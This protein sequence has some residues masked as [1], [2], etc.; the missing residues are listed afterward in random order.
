M[1][2]RQRIERPK[3]HAG[4]QAVFDSKARFRV[5]CAGR[6]WGKTQ[7]GA[8][9]CVEA[10]ARGRGAW[11]VAPHYPIADIGWRM[12]KRLCGTLP[13]VVIRESDRRITMTNYPGWIQVKSASDPDS[14]RG[15]GLDLVVIDEAA[16]VKEAAW[17]EALR[18]ALSDRLGRAVFISTPAGLNWF[19]RLYQRGLDPAQPEWAAWR[20]PTSANPSIAAEEIASA[21]ELL[22]AE[23]FAQEYEAD[24]VEDSNGTLR[25]VVDVSTAL[26]LAEPEADDDYVMGVDLARL[27]DFTALSIFSAR[28]RSEVYLDRFNQVSWSLQVGR[29]RAAAERFGVRKIVVDQTGLGDVVIEQ[30]RREVPA[31]LPVVGLTLT[32]AAKRDVIEGLSLAIERRDLLLLNDP[33][34]LAEA[35]A[36]ARERLPMGGFRYTSPISDDTVIARGL[37]WWGCQPRQHE[38]V[39][40]AESIAN[41]FF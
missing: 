38:S 39:P 14:L 30:L 17:A 1:T 11:W 35:Q 5:V 9:L 27:H 18:P 16:Y 8:W 4:Q 36:Y 34:A 21:R 7:L 25:G 37:A 26:P 40:Q 15:E 2:E 13:G 23:L 32:A 10:A 12:L 28:R 41:P 29:I 6:R 20:Y 24:F 31:D 22:A 3:L 33:L 19:W